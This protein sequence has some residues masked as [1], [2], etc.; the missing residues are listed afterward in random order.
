MRLWYFWFN[1]KYTYNFK[2]T[3]NLLFTSFAG[4]DKI[5][6]I[7]NHLLSQIIS[8]TN[9]MDFPSNHSMRN[10]GIGSILDIQVM[11]PSLDGLISKNE[12]TW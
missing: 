9:R 7:N 4:N 6:R 3:F 2:Y 12:G 5:E 11:L 1:H 10:Y 8:G